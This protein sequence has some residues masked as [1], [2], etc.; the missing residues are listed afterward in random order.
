MVKKSMFDQKGF[1]LIEVIIAAFLLVVALVGAASVTTSVI[2]S[3]FLS[4]TLTT[5]TTLAKDKIE[6]LKATSYSALPTGNTWVTD[7]ATSNGTVQP[8]S[9]GAY[10][11]RE[12]K[13]EVTGTAPNTINQIT[14]TV[15]WP[16]WVPVTVRTIRASD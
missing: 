9:T 8:S 10:Y 12:W 1:T 4:Q 11:K 13:G 5:A 6:E 16:N 7:Y 15:T 3:N 14:A 2:K